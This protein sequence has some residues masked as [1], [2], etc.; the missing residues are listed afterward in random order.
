MWQQNYC[1]MS[2]EEKEIFKKN[3]HL[4]VTEELAVD[5]TDNNVVL[6]FP[7]IPSV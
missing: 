1:Q 4:G 6:G 3:H 7:K 5:P 2:L